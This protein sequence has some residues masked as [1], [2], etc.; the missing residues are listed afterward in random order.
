M[1]L[2]STGYIFPAYFLQAHR[3]VQSLFRQHIAALYTDDRGIHMSGRTF[4]GFQ[5][6]RARTNSFPIGGA[7]PGLGWSV[8]SNDD[9]DRYLQSRSGR[10]HALC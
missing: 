10:S 1:C 5:V 9:I 8:A 6:H 4:T 7:Y 2:E 3:T